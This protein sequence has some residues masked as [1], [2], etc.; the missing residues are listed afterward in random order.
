MPLMPGTTALLGV[1][2]S[3]DPRRN[4][5]GGVRHLTA[6]IA[7]FHHLP[8][9]LA[10]YHAGVGAVSAYGGIPPFPETRTYVARVL[11]VFADLSRKVEDARWRRPARIEPPLASDVYVSADPKMPPRTRSELDTLVRAAESVPAGK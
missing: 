7:R 9:V 5:D 1:R 10:A 8:L 6:L 2:D 11:E 4:I 3:F